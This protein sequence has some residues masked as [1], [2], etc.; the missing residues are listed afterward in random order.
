[1]EAIAFC[2]T[3]EMLENFIE[4]KDLKSTKN[5]KA[6]FFKTNFAS[7]KYF[8]FDGLCRVL[9]NCLEENAISANTVN[10]VQKEIFEA[11]KTQKYKA[12]TNYLFEPFDVEARFKWL[13]EKANFWK[14][15]I[16]KIEVK[17]YD[18]ENG[19]SKTKKIKLRVL[20]TKA[21][22]LLK[23]QGKKQA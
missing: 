13:K 10:I 11:L 3:F 14:N 15:E 18:L 8:E 19:T 21:E 5:K 2:Y 1:M 6:R 9:K 7:T 20:P 17:L 22:V 12:N 23:L 4:V 16:K